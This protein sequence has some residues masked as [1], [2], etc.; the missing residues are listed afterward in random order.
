MSTETFR[1]L[2]LVI[3]HHAATRPIRSPKDA[4]AFMQ[5]RLAPKPREVFAVI[6]LDGR[7]QPIAFTT[8][9]MG[10]ATST[11]VHPREVFSVAVRECAAAV[12]LFHNHPSGD[13]TPSAEDRSITQRLCHAGEIIGISVVDHL[14]VGDRTYFSFNE[15]GLL[16]VGGL[17]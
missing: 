4:I 8:A 9:S 16:P 11:L 14:I 3:T 2:E 17:R 10:T 1:E 7:H 6:L 15:S 13:C 5:S 12:M